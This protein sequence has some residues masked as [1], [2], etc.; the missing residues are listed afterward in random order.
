MECVSQRTM[1]RWRIAEKMGK[2]MKV[3]FTTQSTNTVQF[4]LLLRQ[5][6]VFVLCDHCFKLRRTYTHARL[7][8]WILSRFSLINLLRINL[9]NTSLPDKQTLKYEST[10]VFIA[11]GTTKG[12]FERMSEFSLHFLGWNIKE[13]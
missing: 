8:R 10:T 6:H 1:G 13:K 9:V 11:L 12:C 7:Y 2:L 3:T 5:I 4:Y